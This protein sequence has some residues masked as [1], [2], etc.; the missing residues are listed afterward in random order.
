MVGQG[1][2]HKPTKNQPA[3]PFVL[4][5]EVSVLQRWFGPALLEFDR[6][7]VGSRRQ[8]PRHRYA[9][10]PCQ[11]E[12]RRVHDQFVKRHADVEHGIGIKGDLRSKCLDG[13]DGFEGL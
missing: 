4:R 8:L 12:A 6:I 1:G 11:T 9:L 3:K 5:Q 2:R 7:T 13:M 10:A